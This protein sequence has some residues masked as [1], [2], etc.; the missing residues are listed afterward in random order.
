MDIA[1]NMRRAVPI[2]E[3][4][5]GATNCNEK[6][7]LSCGA[8]QTQSYCCKDHQRLMWTKHKK[9]C[10]LLAL[11]D[12]TIKKQLKP[13]QKA[14]LN[15]HLCPTLPALAV[16]YLRKY[17]SCSLMNGHSNLFINGSLFATEK[18]ITTN[19]QE[20]MSDKTEFDRTDMLKRWG[21]ISSNLG[22]F[23]LIAKPGALFLKKPFTPYK[24]RPQQFRN[25]PVLE[26][27]IL[28]NG[29]TVIEIG[30][31]DFGITLEGIDSLK[32]DGEPLTVVGYEMEP[33]CVAKTLVMLEMMKM[34]TVAARSVVEVW[35]SSLWSETTYDAFRVA[36]GSVLSV[37]KGGGGVVGG[38]AA[39][40]IKAVLSYWQSLPKISAKTALDFQSQQVFRESD[41]KYAMHACNLASEEDRVDSIR[42]NF[43]KAL[44]EDATT[45]VGSV[46]MNS[47]SKAARVSQHFGS[48]IEAAPASVHN[49]N[50]ISQQ[51]LTQDHP[52]LFVRL[53][54]YFEKRIATYAA[55][56]RRGSLVFTPKLGNVS[57]ENDALIQEIK[58]KDPWIISW[59][60]VNDY[61][62]PSVFHTIGKRMSGRNTAHY[63]HSCNWTSLV[64]GTDPFDI[65][66]KVRLSFFAGGLMLLESLMLRGLTPQVVYH[67]RD[68][69]G[70]QLIRMYVF[71]F[72][73]RFL[74]ILHDH[75]SNQQDIHIDSKD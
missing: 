17:P 74:L 19:L 51:G 68:I 14:A 23:L 38:S 32:L 35:V 70:V 46:V 20:M 71:F 50:G 18:M 45:T 8:C 55:H 61:L 58:A 21:E 41:S 47:E 59:S 67:F 66:E 52:T 39:P 62:E 37:G 12:P 49:H 63:L 44:Y 60:N 16:E 40:E 11:F 3:D 43:T 48:C 42:Y 7:T 24:T 4:V 1:E 13:A 65:N 2:T 15:R 10:K 22:E 31:V 26:P 64:F 30:F 33:M 36:L 28:V 73:Y 29:T 5:C 56:V 6:G 72:I 54:M 34:Q 75:T 69:C 9:I 27:I 57:L 25:S 53:R